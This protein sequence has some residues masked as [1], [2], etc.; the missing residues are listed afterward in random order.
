M[1]PWLI[2]ALKSPAATENNFIKKYFVSQ[3]THHAIVQSSFLKADLYTR[4]LVCR[5]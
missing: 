3:K 2:A 1:K 5:T 4:K